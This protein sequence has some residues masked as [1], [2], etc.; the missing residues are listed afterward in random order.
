MC[1]ICIR[2]LSFSPWQV[3]S[4][5]YS[6]LCISIY[7][8][9][10]FHIEYWK[11]RYWYIKDY[12]YGFVQLSKKSSDVLLPFSFCTSRKYYRIDTVQ[13]IMICVYFTSPSIFS[14]FNIFIYHKRIFWSM[15]DKIILKKIMTKKLIFLFSIFIGVLI[16]FVFDFFTEKCVW[17]IYWIWTNVNIWTFRKL[18]I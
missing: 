18:P 16:L 14:A 9:R 15:K 6:Y 1:F 7:I 5:K 8:S 2:K 17:E 11:F 12:W 3:I 13:E 10:F 4:D